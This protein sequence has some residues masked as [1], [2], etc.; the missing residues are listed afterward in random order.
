MLTMGD[1]KYK[2]R[3]RPTLQSSRKLGMPPQTGLFSIGGRVGTAN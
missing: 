2:P 1:G 3:L